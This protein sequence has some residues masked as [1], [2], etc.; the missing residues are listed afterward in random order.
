MDAHVSRTGTAG[1]DGIEQRQ[2]P[3]RPIDGEGADRALLVGTHPIGLIGGIQP[4][5]G[6]IQGQATR[7]GPHLVDAGGRHGPGGTIHPEKVD[8]SA[9]AGRQVHL[10]RQHV[11][12]RRAERAD[13]SNQR[14]NGFVRWRLDRTGDERGCPRHG[15]R[16]LQERTP[17]TVEWSHGTDP[18]SFFAA[19]CLKARSPESFG[20]VDTGPSRQSHRIISGRIAPPNFC[21]WL[22]IPHE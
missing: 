22:F 21:P 15:A 11:A 4:G 19:G 16:D 17:G 3:V 20:S 6:A 18:W 10:R 1:P 2:T 9:V 13:I 14:P 7:A 12:E 8:A 5:P